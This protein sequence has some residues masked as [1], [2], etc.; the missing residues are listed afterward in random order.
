MDIARKPYEI[1]LWEDVLTFVV[2]RADGIKI[3]YEEK[4]PSDAS[5]QV[6]AQ[7]YKERKIC[8]IGSDTMNTPIR[9]V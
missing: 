3:E 2:Q 8:I 6:I 4:I 5:G 1:S 7:Y 9:A